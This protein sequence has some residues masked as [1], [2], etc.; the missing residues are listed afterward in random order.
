MSAPLL[1][2]SLLLL[3]P[4]F[5]LVYFLGAYFFFY[6]GGYD[7]PPAV[8]ISFEDLVSPT[9][10]HATFTEVPELHPGMLLVDGG[11][12]NNF[13][14]TQEIPVRCKVEAKSSSKRG[15]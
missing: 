3:L 5:A 13:T 6:R 4:L 15:G 11:H 9:S 14:I 2:I 12:R 8:D 7:A 1:K 10:S